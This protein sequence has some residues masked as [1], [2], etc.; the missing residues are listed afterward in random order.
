MQVVAGISPGISWMLQLPMWGL[1]LLITLSAL[2]M[3]LGPTSWDRLLGFSQ[4]SALCIP[5]LVLMSILF[6]LDYLLDIAITYALLGFIGTL[7]M[8]RFI[9]RRGKEDMP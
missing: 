5:F 8:A 9:R 1:L 4:L 2:R 6:R 3:I 7:F